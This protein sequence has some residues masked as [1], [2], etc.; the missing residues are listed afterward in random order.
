MDSERAVQRLTPT[1]PI[2]SALPAHGPSHM[3]IVRAWEDEDQF[4]CTY[5]D[6]SFGAGVLCQVDHVRPLAEGGAHEL[7]NVAPACES[8]NRQKADR[9][10]EVWLAFLAGDGGNGK[11]SYTRL[12]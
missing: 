6:A 12:R 3:D 8:C 7:W 1:P 2:R 11:H 5:C 4:S 10:A 9:P